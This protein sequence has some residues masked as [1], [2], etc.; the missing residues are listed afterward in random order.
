[1]TANS[2]NLKSIDGCI[3]E[4]LRVVNGEE[5]KQ[6]NWDAFREIFLESSNFTVYYGDPETPFETAS[7]DDMIEFMQDEYYNSGYK[8]EVLERSIKEFNG[9]AHVFEIVKH[10]EPDGN[11]TKGLNSYQLIY[12]K[13]RWYITNII[14][15]SESKDLEIPSTFLKQ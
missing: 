11:S 8:E 12:G 10:T 5:G 1:M 14:W 4:M 15:T 2:D 7:V 9:I 13:N 3:D 6:R